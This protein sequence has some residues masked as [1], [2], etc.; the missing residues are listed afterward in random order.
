LLSI[1]RKFQS[2]QSMEFSDEV[3]TINSAST[4]ERSSLGETQFL[5][6][7]GSDLGIGKRP[8]SSDNRL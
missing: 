7:L 4:K 1:F 8:I 5:N 3:T 6:L 2:R